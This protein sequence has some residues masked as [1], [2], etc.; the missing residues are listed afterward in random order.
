MTLETRQTQPETQLE[1]LIK[2][3][4]LSRRLHVQVPTKLTA[5]MTTYI[6]IFIEIRIN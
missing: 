6:Y 4:I 1:K 3:I 5:D 2:I